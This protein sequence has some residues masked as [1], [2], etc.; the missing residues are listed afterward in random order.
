MP[1]AQTGG[2]GMGTRILASM[3]PGFGP[4][5]IAHCA[6]RPVLRR[7]RFPCV[8]HAMLC[9]VFR[10]GVPGA[11]QQSHGGASPCPALP[12]GLIRV[13]ADARTSGIAAPVSYVPHGTR[14]ALELEGGGVPKPGGTCQ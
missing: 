5:A 3:L 13:V 9:R 12:H 2:G 1:G 14:R 11:A 10:C 4:F 6:L 8:R 7:I